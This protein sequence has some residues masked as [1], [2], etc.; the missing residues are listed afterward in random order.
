MTT[1]SPLSESCIGCLAVHDRI[2][3]QMLSVTCRSVHENPPLC[4]PELIPWYTPSCSLRSSSELLRN[5]PGPKD[6]KTKRYDQQTISE[7]TEELC[8]SRGGCHG[9][10][11]P[12]SH[13]GLCGRKATLNLNSEPPDLCERRVCGRPGLPVPNSP[14]GLCGRKLR[15]IKTANFQI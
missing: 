4:L 11:V 14:C 10:P 15:N 6:H 8:K 3:H 7:L 5:V 1:S 13:Y 2:L 12:N 9:L